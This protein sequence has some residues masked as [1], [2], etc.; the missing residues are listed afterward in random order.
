[1]AFGIGTKKFYKIWNLGPRSCWRSFQFPTLSTLKVSWLEVEAFVFKCPVGFPA[2]KYFPLNDLKVKPLPLCA[3]VKVSWVE[4]I[5]EFAFISSLS[6]SP[7]RYFPWYPF[8]WTLLSPINV[9][10]QISHGPIAALL[11]FAWPDS[12]ATTYFPL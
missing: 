10:V 8:N 7:F 1:M 12:S 4:A 11:A 2:T 9:T 5:G 3:T 6:F